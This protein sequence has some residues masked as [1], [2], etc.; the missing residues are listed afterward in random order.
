MKNSEIVSDIENHTLPRS[1]DTMVKIR[2]HVIRHIMIQII[3]IKL[4]KY[5]L[6]VFSNG[7]IFT[8]GHGDEG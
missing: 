8:R 7:M 3:E 1:I 6:L 5:I 4:L 2:R